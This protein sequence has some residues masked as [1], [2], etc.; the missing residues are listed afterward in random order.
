MINSRRSTLRQEARGGEAPF[1]WL[2]PRRTTVGAPVD[3]DAAIE[4]M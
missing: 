3:N 1:G 4:S 2:G